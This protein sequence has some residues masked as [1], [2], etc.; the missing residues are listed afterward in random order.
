LRARY[1]TLPTAV[2]SFV[3]NREIAEAARAELRFLA[4][5][6]LTAVMQ[7]RWQSGVNAS[8]ALARTR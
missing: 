2:L 1:Q 6:R 3:A 5:D 8:C 4:Y 7:K